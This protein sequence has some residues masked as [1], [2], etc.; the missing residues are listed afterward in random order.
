VSKKR[1]LGPWMFAA[2]SVAALANPGFVSTGAS[3]AAKLDK[4]GQTLPLRHAAGSGPSNEDDIDTLDAI[5]ESLAVDLSTEGLKRRATRSLRTLLLPQTRSTQQQNA[6]AFVQ[7]FFGLPIR[8]TT[9]LQ[10]ARQAVQELTEEYRTDAVSVE[11]RSRIERAVKDIDAFLTRYFDQYALGDQRASKDDV[12]LARDFDQIDKTALKTTVLAQV[13]KNRNNQVDFLIATLPD[14]IDSYT[15]WQFDPMLDAIA[16]A[17]SASDYVLDRFHFP[18]SDPEESGG[19]TAEHGRHHELEPGVVIFRRHIGRGS[20]DDSHHTEQDVS[21]KAYGDRLVLLL[22]H[23]NPAA[24]IHT[25]ALMN[26]IRLVINCR[27]LT[28]D[29]PVTRNTIRILGPVFSGSSETLNRTL[30]MVS[31]RGAD[32]YG[33][34]VI[35]GSATDPQNKG[36]IESGLTPKDNS[37][38]TVDFHATVHSDDVL[39]PKLVGEITA[40]QWSK[41]VA[42]LFEAN[43]QYGRQLW[44][45]LSRPSAKVKSPQEFVQLPFPMNISRLRTTIDAQDSSHTGALGLPSRLRPLAME[46]Q[47]NPSDQIPQF[48]PKTTATYVELALSGMLETMHREHVRTVAL[49]AT[50]PR[51]KLFLAQQIARYSPDVSLFTAESDSLYI[52]PDYAAYLRGALVVS[53]YPLYSGNQRWSYGYQG[54]S[55]QRQFANGSAQGIYNATLALLDYTAAG[56]PIGSA[57]PLLEYGLPGEVCPKACKPPVWISVVGRSSAW[58]IRAHLVDDSSDYVFGVTPTAVLRSPRVF[59]SPGFHAL[60]ILLTFAILISW[61]TQG[62]GGFT[63]LAGRERRRDDTDASPARRAYL[64]VSLSGVL[65]IQTF[66]WVLCLIR[67]R[68]EDRDPLAVLALVTASFGLVAACHMTARALAPVVRAYHPAVWRRLSWRRV[69]TWS[70]SA[71]VL[72]CAWSLG[73]IALYLGDHAVRNRSDVVSFIARALDFGNGVCPTLPVLFLG[74]ALTLWGLTEL[75]RVGRGRVALADTAVH[76]MLQH[77]MYTDVEKLTSPLGL[78]NQSIL[79]VPAGGIA[80]AAFVFLATCIFAFDPFNS[81]LVT[82]EGPRFG[83][84]VSATLLLVQVMITLA[85]AQFAFLWSRIKQLLEFMAR[86]RLAEAYKRVPRELFPTQLFPRVPRLGDLH[87]AVGHWER[88]AA[89]AEAADQE[90]W[91]RPADSV[92]VGA[93]FRQEMYLSPDAPWGAS[94]TWHALLKAASSG[95]LRPPESLAPRAGHNVPISTMQP[96]GTYH[97]AAVVDVIAA[98]R[99]VVQREE[100]LPAMLV[101]FVVRDALARLAQNLIFVIGGVVL[102]FCSHTLFPF[103]QHTQLQVVGWIYVGITFT[104]ILTVLVQIKR[105]EIVASLTSA[106]PGVTTTWDGE[107]VLKITVVALLPLFALFAAQFP[108]IGGLLLRLVEPVQKA[109]P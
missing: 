54:E 24:G 102:V 36:T 9:E 15:G 89:A 65:L 96:E 11:S 23:E 18:D 14:P 3:G 41:R 66:V 5:G 90:G 72:V 61:A 101:G 98:D 79:S 81:W 92:D 10:R 20:G 75:S 49:M 64:L 84:F 71:A 44:K 94:R 4:P 77:I 83:R 29:D 34:R 68:V 1:T 80:V 69:S 48:N 100:E 85:V 37:S 63:A 76:P 19:T 62:M 78:L 40:A 26:A 67:V 53:T 43:T 2:V 95:G 105:N 22:V 70:V 30:R 38:L 97:A 93:L 109:L 52:H 46:T 31:S 8:E 13:V 60:L 12:L 86:H 104:T 88:L 74:S 28:H 45:V 103:Q 55:E 73:N 16:Q 42:V 7:A 50:D 21:P 108:D 33:V 32:G 91:Q 99:A 59:P 57:P 39:L 27:E 58:P 56:E 107:F 17:V 47:G 82:I 25:R 106:T 6:I 35:S 87:I 51:D